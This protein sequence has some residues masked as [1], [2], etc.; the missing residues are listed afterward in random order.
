MIKPRNSVTCL[1]VTM[2]VLVSQIFGVILTVAVQVTTVVEAHERDSDEG[3]RA[4]RRRARSIFVDK[5]STA[6]LEKGMASAP[7][8]TI[9]RAL[10]HARSLRFGSSTHGIR[11]H[12]GI[13]NLHVAA[14]PG[15]YVGSFDPAV[16]DPSSPTYDLS[17]EKLP[18]L[19][20]IP[21]LKLHGGTTL[22]KDDDGLPESVVP[23]PS[24]IVVA[25]R[26]QGSK[27][28]L[29]LIT[30]THPLE[31][32]ETEMAGDNVTI[33]G[34][35]LQADPARQLPS[36]LIGVDGVIDFVVRENV[37]T[38]GGMGVWTRLS[39][40]R[41]ADNLAV[42]NNV[43]FFLTAGSNNSPAKLNVETNR[44]SGNADP[45]AG[46]TLVGSGDTGNRRVDLDFGANKFRRIPLP[47][48]F[49]RELHPDEVPDTLYA[50]VVGNEFD[51][52][53]Q[54]QNGIRVV[55]YLQDPYSAV[56]GQDETANI[57]A[58]FRNNVTKSNLHYGIVVDAGQIPLS[59]RRIVTMQLSFED[60][61][62]EDNGLGPAI[63]SLW[64]YAG[65]IGAPFSAPNPT[66]AHDST[67][68]ACGDVTRF[69]YDN[70]QDPDP[71]TNPAPTNNR[72]TVNGLE[73]SGLCT[74]TCSQE[75]PRVRRCRDR[76]FGWE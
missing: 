2:L 8:R 74:G 51:G 61:I 62:L 37:L 31:D 29:M 20:N 54:Q 18:L 42:N 14:S 43:G 13:I 76:R 73:L 30:R 47:T 12:S 63:F 41:I 36:S 6:V 24:T 32:P 10:E 55:G 44:T 71:P 65:S 9:T 69:H 75:V 40:G 66:F 38:N 39:S 26:P 64:R 53:G 25:D 56:V 7:F 60:N 15:P 67:I 48:V 33:T 35:W 23:G 21:N 11:P 70:R 52:N 50:R 22:V 59:D 58:I 34:F 27:Q 1:A 19:I 4:N 49:D 3:L 17:K 72:L 28:Y 46:V 5:N 68:E 16:F 57:T 45:G